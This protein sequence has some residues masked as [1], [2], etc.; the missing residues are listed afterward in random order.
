VARIKRWITQFCLPLTRASTDAMRHAWLYSQPQSITA[1]WPILISCPA[2]GRRLSC[3]GRRLPGVTSCCV[4][5]HLGYLSLLPS[6]G[7]EV[8]CE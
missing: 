2:D 1:L 7:W 5:G 4:T 8:N 6:V 3:T